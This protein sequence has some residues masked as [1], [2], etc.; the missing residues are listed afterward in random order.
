MAAMTGAV[1]PALSAILET[2]HDAKMDANHNHY[3]LNAIL[4]AWTQ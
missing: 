4:L 2:W 1:Q 3:G